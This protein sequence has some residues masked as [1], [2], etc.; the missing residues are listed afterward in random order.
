MMAHTE[1]GQPLYLW[2]A[3][4]TPPVIQQRDIDESKPCRTMLRVAPQQPQSERVQ[5]ND[6]IH[7]F[8]LGGLIAA[9]VDMS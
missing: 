4:L 3:L 7:M 9:G 2:L 1:R 5:I 8:S 6:A